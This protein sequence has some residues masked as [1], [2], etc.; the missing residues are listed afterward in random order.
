MFQLMRCL[1]SCV[2]YLIT[3]LIIVRLFVKSLAAPAYKKR[4][5]ERFGVYSCS[6]H[7]ETIWLHAVSV[8]EV[9]AI[10]PL[11]KHLQDLYPAHTL[12]VT[13]TT[14]TGSERVHAVLSDSV[15]HVY[16]PY[17]LPDVIQRFM[18]HFQPKLAIIVETEIWP[19]LFA[20]CATH[21]IPLYLINARLSEKSFRAYQNLALLMRPTLAGI[22]HIATQTE[23][24][25]QRFIALGAIPQHVETLGNIK[26]DLSNPDHYLGQGRD[27]KATLFKHRWVWL[28]ASTHPGEEALCCSS[29]QVLKNQ[30]P[31]L[32]LVLAPRHPERFT[33]IKKEAEQLGLQVITRRSGEPCSAATDIFLLDTLGELKMLYYSADCA[34]IGGS[35]VPIGGHNFLEALIAEVPVVFGPY[36]DNFKEIASHAVNQHAALQCTHSTALTD[37]LLRMYN[38]PE[39]RKQLSMQGKAFVLQNQGTLAALLKKLSLAIKKIS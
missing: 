28:C 27:L 3:P 2:F 15:S 31:E 13:T 16:L 6:A 36:M 32:L 38:R 26:F 24:D 19:N 18:R 4:W 14:P 11:I 34:L 8:G 22:T 10:F 17:D 1:Y 29:Y 39:L 25:S 9:E 5:P 35:F 30:I 21:T 37:T 12:L 20:Y 33:T 7:K 23:L